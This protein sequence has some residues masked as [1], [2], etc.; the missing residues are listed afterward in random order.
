MDVYEKLG[1]RPFI[2]A[3][4]PLTRL[5]GATLPDCVVEAMTEASRKNIRLRTLQ[6]RV[7]QAIAKLTNN[8]GA[9]VSC[10]AASGITLAVAAC[11]AGTDPVLS[12]QLPDPEGMKNEIIVHA[13]SR[14]FK[15]DAAIRCAGARIVRIGTESGATRGDLVT[16][17]NSHTAAILAHD[18]NHIG[19]I[20]LQEIV[21]I[22]KEH[23]LPV[24]VDA[25][26]SVPPKDN[27]WRFTRDFGADAVFISGGKGLR[28]PQTTGLVLGKAWIVDACAFH[29]VPNNRIGRGMKVGKEELAGIYAAVKLFIEKDDK[30]ARLIKIQ[31]LESIIDSVARLPGIRIHKLGGVRVLIRC[32]SGLY[33][34]APQSAHEWLLMA[35][36]AVYVEP[37]PDGLMISTECLEEGQEA[38][39]SHQLQNLFVA[40]S[41]QHAE[42][43]G[44]PS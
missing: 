27:L 31:Q 29:G 10:G 21:V 23:G 38:I 37:S 5:G 39:V 15:S 26:F 40:C 18:T 22:A 30:L 19:T 25:A 32:D 24:L 12:A 11:M 16:A 43:S 17:I 2:N 34:F 1:V 6:Q 20:P 7:G 36:P 28:G 33:R 4:R 44:C 8:E 13:C 42:N 35:D 14:G 41:Y 3:Y 9:Y